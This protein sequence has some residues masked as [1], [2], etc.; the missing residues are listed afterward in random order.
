MINYVSLPI[1]GPFS[2]VVMWYKSSTIVVS[3][4]V[5]F[6]QCKVGE[7]P[8]HYIWHCS[9]VSHFGTAN[10]YALN[11]TLSTLH[12]TLAKQLIQ[13]LSESCLKQRENTRWDQQNGRNPTCFG[14]SQSKS[15]TSFPVGTATATVPAPKTGAASHVLKRGTRD[16]T[17]SSRIQFPLRLNIPKNEQDYFH[18]KW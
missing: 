17:I 14:V 6:L 11:W 10:F 9:N 16:E 5:L 8:I 1:H 3:V 18:W 7:N 13:S 4:L 12:L 2:F 15:L